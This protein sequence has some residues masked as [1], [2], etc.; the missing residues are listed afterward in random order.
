MGGAQTGNFG[1]LSLSSENNCSTEI[2]L[3]EKKGDE[4][5][6]TLN[7]LWVVE[8]GNDSEDRDMELPLCGE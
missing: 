7:N 2:S 6:T 8:S 4:R 3:I 5:Q 1:D